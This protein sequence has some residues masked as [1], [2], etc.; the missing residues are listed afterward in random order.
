MLVLPTR[1]DQIENEL[2][3]TIVIDI[4]VTML[5]VNIYTQ[6]HVVIVVATEEVVNEKV[7]VIN[8][9]KTEKVDIMI[10][11]RDDIGEKHVSILTRKISRKAVGLR[12]EIISLMQKMV[13]INAIILLVEERRLLVVLQTDL[14]LVAVEVNVRI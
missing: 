13:V 9:I 3:L 2:H 8:S 4:G 14:L 5:I 10:T 6:K 7:V 12:A 11:H 1:S